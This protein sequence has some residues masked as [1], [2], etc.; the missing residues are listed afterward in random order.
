MKKYI[1]ATLIALSTSLIPSMA[2]ATNLTGNGS[3]F[4]ANFI[5]QCRVMYQ[6]DTGN[7]IQYIA[8]GSGAGRNAF[9]NS[10][11][12]FAVSDVPY[13]KTDAQPPKE[14]I[15]VP[16]VAGPVAVI[17]NLP[18][19][20]G[21]LRLSKSVLSKIFA[22]QIKMWNDPQIQK[23]NSVKLPKMRIFVIYRADGSGTSEVFTSY[24]NSVAP[25][26]WNKPGNKTFS[27][28]FPS[29]IN[30][31]VPYFQAVSGSAQVAATQL[32]FKGSIAYNEVSYARTLKAAL[33]ENESGKFIAPT[34]AASASFLS[35][36]QFNEDGSAVLNY[37]NPSPV[38]YNISTFSYGIAYKESGEAASD[39]KLFFAYAITKCNKINGY[40]PIVGNA[41]TVAKKQIMKI[42]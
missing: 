40:A 18:G 9:N 33:I 12:N 21:Q 16:L 38:A 6:R 34:P 11:V 39:I 37:R 25:L 22:G 24:L 8:N 2:N 26:V 35:K 14:I 28:A 17:Y 41:L 32:L 20:K 7:S 3:T 4:A 29:D 31:F 30:K 1:L 36:L 23:L 10:L 5:E 42:K 27:S 19:Y 13:A 15:Y